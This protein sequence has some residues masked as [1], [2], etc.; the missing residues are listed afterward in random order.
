MNSR[1][2]GLSTFES[3]FDKSG[4]TNFT[5]N[6]LNKIDTASFICHGKYIPD[7]YKQYIKT[8]EDRLECGKED[9]GKSYEFLELITRMEFIPE[10]HI[11]KVS[12]Y[13]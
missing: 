12:Q 10:I 8:L 7:A 13:L 9:L 4:F 11:Q 3:P 5:K 6:L 1:H 2:K